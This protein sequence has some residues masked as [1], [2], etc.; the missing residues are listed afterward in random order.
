LTTIANQGAAGVEENSR[1]ESIERIDLVTDATANTL[2]LTVNDIIDMSGMNLYNTTNGWTNGTYT[3]GASASKHQLIVDGD[4]AD[5][6][7]INAGNGSWVSA[8]TVTNGAA[9][10]NV[11]DNIAANSQILALNGIVVTNNDV[12]AIAPTLT[13]STPIDNATVVD[14]TSNIVLTFSE[15]VTA[16]AGKNI[17]IKKTSDNSTVATIDAADAQVSIAANIATIN[18]TSNLAKGVEY[19]V[20]ID[21]GAFKDYSNNAYT[22]IGS[23]TALS[24]TT[25]SAVHLSTIAAGTGGIC[26]QR[27]SLRRL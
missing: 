27:S 26:N 4:A 1:I 9:T 8:G 21:S 11:Y 6:L 5:S 10:Y 25:D 22:G 12:D 24:F 2:T 3:L 18:P 17:I 14:E 20:L 19:Y 23:T 15:N 7:V 16:V 13:S